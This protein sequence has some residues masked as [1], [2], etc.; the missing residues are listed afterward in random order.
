MSNIIDLT[1]TVRSKHYRWLVKFYPVPTCDKR[2]QHWHVDYNLHGFTHVDSLLHMLPG[3]PPIDEVPLDKFMGE[4]AVVNLSHLGAD[5]AVT[6]ADLEKHGQHVR[7]GDIVLLHTDWPR[8]TDIASQDFWGKAP[9][10]A[11]DACEWL[12]ARKVKTVGYDYPPDYVNKLEVTDPKHDFKYEEYT[13]HMIF[14]PKNIYVIEYLC[15][16]HL[17]KKNRVQ[18][19]ALPIPF[20]GAEGSPVRA[21][22][23]ED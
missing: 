8:K 13:T 7:A 2:S 11:A 15:N 3:T 18:F 12:V 23:I 17:I 9:Y 5:D 10:T 1:F 16:L 19:M 6:A 4:A 20:E 21:I 22:A 14:F